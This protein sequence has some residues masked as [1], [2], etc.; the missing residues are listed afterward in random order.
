MREKVY[1]FQ[2]FLRLYSKNVGMLNLNSL[3]YIKGHVNSLFYFHYTYI[4]LF[5]LPL[6]T[7]YIFQHKQ[8]STFEVQRLG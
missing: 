6:Y 7:T 3:G 4:H 8:N 5:I 2:V 1:L